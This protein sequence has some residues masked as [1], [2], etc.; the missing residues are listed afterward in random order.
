MDGIG[1][2]RGG[3]LSGRKE[4]KLWL[5]CKKKIKIKKPNNPN[6]R[7]LFSSYRSPMIIGEMILSK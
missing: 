1:K 7:P 6:K 5:G 2:S 4:Q 3:G